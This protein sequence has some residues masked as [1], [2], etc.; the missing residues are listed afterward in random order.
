MHNNKTTSIMIR[1]TK[2]SFTAEHKTYADAL[3]DA[4]LHTGSI[5]GA[6]AKRRLEIN[7]FEVEEVNDNGGQEDEPQEQ[8]QT[9]GQQQ[10]AKD[11]QQ[12]P[13]G[14]DDQPGEDQEEQKEEKQQQEQEEM[15]KEEPKKEEKLEDIP[16]FLKPF[17]K[18]IERNITAKMAE[19][20]ETAKNVDQDT[21][22]KLINEALKDYDGGEGRK[23]TIKK[24]DGSTKKIGKQHKKFEM[25]LACVACRL[26]TLLVGPAGTGKTHASRAVSEALDLEFWYNAISGQSTM[27]QFFGYMDANGNYVTTAFREA[28]EK[29]GVYLLDEFDAGNANILTSLNAAIANGIASFPDGMIKAHKDF[30]CIAAANTFGTGATSEYNGRNRIDAATLDR[31]TVIKWDYDEELETEMAINKEWCKFIQT[32]RLAVSDLQGIKAVISPRAM[33]QGE[34]LLAYGVNKKDV[35]ESTVFKGMTEKDVRMIN[36]KIKSYEKAAA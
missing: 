24:P 15:K 13:G 6:K 8:P 34:K 33:Q 36:E 4:G 7:G 17:L 2:G 5:S 20:A 21:V 18:A 11:D 12:E 3:R 9:K 27:S 26:N 32:V 29:G 19:T 1:M 23:I 31:F 16:E 25:L 35:L 30:I 10:E 22:N 28:Y 14:E